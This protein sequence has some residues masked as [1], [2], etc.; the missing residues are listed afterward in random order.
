MNTRMFFLGLGLCSSVSLYAGTMGPLLSI[1]PYNGFYIG[2]DVGVANLMDKESTPYLPGVYDRHQFSATGLVGGG[3][4]GYD[5]S[6]NER[7]KLGIE[8][9]INATALNSAAEQ[10]YSS[11]SS[12]NVNMKYN[13]GARVLP[14]YEFS[15]GTVG[16][17]LLGY[18]Y[19]KFNIK[20]NGDYGFIDKGL[21]AN[22][23]QAGLGFNVPLHYKNLSLRGDVLY[24]GYGA[25]NSLGLSS[26]LT[27]EN[28]YNHFSV[29]EGNL[30]LVY[31]YL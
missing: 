21:S 27:P 26:S 13:T 22:G 14:G 20:D 11:F 19:G 30:A 9:F 18:S 5:Y 6:V 7:I 15:P 4:L 31:K 24:T 25:N 29:I 28:Y 12:Y 17:I 10:H 16:H 23:F 8:G 2:A 3:L 1:E